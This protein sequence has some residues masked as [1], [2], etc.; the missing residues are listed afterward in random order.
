[1]I[2]SCSK[3]NINP[4]YKPISFGR[5]HSTYTQNGIDYFIQT[6]GCKNIQNSKMFIPHYHGFSIPIDCK[7]LPNTKL[8][9]TQKDIEYKKKICSN[10]G[11]YGI[12]PYK[13]ASVIGPDEFKD[14]I[15]N[16][17]SNRNFYVTGERPQDKLNIPDSNKLENVSMKIF[18]GDYHVHTINS[19][20]SLSVE[21]VLN[22][23]V[24]YGNEYAKENGT[25]FIIGITDHNTVEGCKQAVKIIAS[26]PDKYK[27]I[28]VVLGVEISTKEAELNGYKFKKPEKYHILAM[29][30]DPFD[31]KLNAF[32]DDLKSQ[33][34]NPLNIKAI[35]VQDAY[36]G[37]CHQVIPVIGLQI[38]NYIK[39]L[40]KHV[41][42]WDCIKPAVLMF[43][44]N[45][46]FIAVKEL[47]ENNY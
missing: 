36:D 39:Q 1:M 27:N 2:N 29:C 32:L 47:N 45:Q 37:V 17:S 11:I 14:A 34:G 13:L 22:Q 28:R 12:K 4:L 35:S 24:E 10:T 40:L 25:P 9:G 30:I 41:I 21:D 20:G 31:P 44:E 43:T 23:A 7:N 26:N 18:G 38:L 42:T 46:Y 8:E 3:V 16:N 5:K 15:I 19:D 33:S 6:S